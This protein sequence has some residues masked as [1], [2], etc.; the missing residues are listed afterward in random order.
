MATT[1]SINVTVY[2]RVGNSVSQLAKPLS[3]GFSAHSH[4]ETLPSVETVYDAYS[5]IQGTALHSFIEYG[6]QKFYVAETAAQIAA[7]ANA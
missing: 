3:M 1:N 6:G 5:G 7:L 2:K 4:Y